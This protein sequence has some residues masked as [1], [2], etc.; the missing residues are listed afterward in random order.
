M[1]SALD[2]PSSPTVGQTY[3]SP[4]VTGQPTYQWDGAQWLSKFALGKEY[5][6]LDGSTPMTGLLTL[7]GA[8][9]NPLHA[10]TKAYTDAADA[11]LAAS[12]GGI[13]TSYVRYDTAQ[14]LTAGQMAQARQNISAPLRGWISGLTLSAA[15]ATA[16]FGVAAGEASDSGNVVLMQLASAYTKTTSNWA[17]GSGNGALDTGAISAASW[18]HVFLIRRPDTGVVDVLVSLSPT[19]P[20][21]PA[22]YTQFRRIGSLL[23]TASQWKKFYQEGDEFLWDAFVYDIPSMVLT[24]TSTV[25]TLASVP[26]GIKVW[27]VLIVDCNAASGGLAAA[28]IQSGDVPAMGV[29][30]GSINVGA[31]G[32]GV[33]GIRGFGQY[34]LRTNTSAQIRAGAFTGT[35]LNFAASTIGYIDRRGRDS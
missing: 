13:V 16:T 7:S 9:A 4:P 20:T 21:L 1:P 19:A 11:G 8:P 24:V 17:V 18:Y 22:N 10:A 31:G 12:I 6:A 3:P 27:A 2:F 28:I 32:T 33:A 25:F 23:T 30:S 34:I 29:G 5:V 26:T 14:S 35:S 15:G